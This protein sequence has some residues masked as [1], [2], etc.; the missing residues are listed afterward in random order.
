M[1]DGDDTFA[2]RVVHWD[3][4][5]GFGFIERDDGEPDAFLHLRQ[6]AGKPDFLRIGQRVRFRMRSNQRTGR[7]Q[8]YDA[9]VLDE[10]AA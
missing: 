9:I 10:V 8:A 7:P 4:E 6:V 3:I 2:G 1:I 5:R